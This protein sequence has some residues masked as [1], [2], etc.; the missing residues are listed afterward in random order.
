VAV[1]FALLSAATYGVGDFCGGM[2]A[3]RVPATTV[4]L[5]SHLLGLALLG[6]VA[7]VVDG[8]ATDGDLL[9]GGVGG[10][11]GAA[12]VGFLYKGL[13]I[14]PMSVVAP[15]TALLSASVPVVVG[16]FEGERPS[17]AAAIGMAGALFA[18]VLVSAEGGGSFR[19]SDLRG[20]GFALAA[21]LGFGLFF[22]A[23]AH[24]GDDSGLWPLVAARTASVTTVGS[25]AL[26]GRVSRAAPAPGARAFTAAAG[27]LDAA[28]NVFY[29]LASREGL[30]SVV[31]VLTALYPVSTVVLARVVLKERFGTTQR[32]GMALAVPAAVLMAI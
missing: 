25:L 13:S 11:C 14:G 4:L 23:L 15:I 19:P 10:L 26:L 16:L 27:S 30:L 32:I 31:S 8:S 29:L 2:A 12:G 9:I 1:V 3:R 21:G 5:W 28:A 17:P 7:L 20:V 24:T 22:V 6:A 18:I